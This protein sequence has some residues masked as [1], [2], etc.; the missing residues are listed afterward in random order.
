MDG[1]TGPNLRLAKPRDGS[2]ISVC[3]F[4][5]NSSTIKVNK[6]IKP[7]EADSD[8]WSAECTVA[9]K[10]V[11]KRFKVKNCNVDT[12][13]YFLLTSLNNSTLNVMPVSNY[14]YLEPVIEGKG[15]IKMM[16]EDVPQNKLEKKL[17]MI[18]KE[19]DIKTPRPNRDSDISYITSALSLTAV[20]KEKVN[21]DFE[22]DDDDD[23]DNDNNNFGGQEVEKSERLTSYG[24]K[25][26]NLLKQQVNQEVDDELMQYEESKEGGSPASS[27]AGSTA[28]KQSSA[29]DEMQNKVIRV[30]R[31]NM[32]RMPIKLLLDHFQIKTKNN[33]F[34]A[35]Q[36]I[37][38]R[39]CTVGLDNSRGQPIKIVT[40]KA[41][42]YTH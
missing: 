37:I 15:N 3:L 1:E 33:A 34:K 41:E 42:F 36:D 24:Q 8:I 39:T 26:K 29:I 32:G 14:Q 22:G 6:L 2:S 38:K 27:V 18:L 5:E 23:D 19:E 30:I 31:Q 16:D 35:M 28:S 10:T 25:V 13:C 12:S 9:N 20:R 11:A 4:S 21:W 17:E 40:L 7:D